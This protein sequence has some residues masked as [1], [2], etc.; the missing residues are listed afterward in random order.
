MVWNTWDNIR[1]NDRLYFK[2]KHYNDHIICEILNLKDTVLCPVTST[3]LS[4]GCLDLQI[5]QCVDYAFVYRINW[6]KKT[7][8]GDN[9]ILLHK[10][11][12]LTKETF[13]SF[14]LPLGWANSLNILV[15]LKNFF[16]IY[17]YSRYYI[18]IFL[19]VVVMV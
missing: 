4:E 6:R 19:A 7:C 17:K 1:P 9:R 14:H 18:L 3:Y 16:T 10:Y 15:V 13:K 2:L 12:K 8:P 5:C 11:E